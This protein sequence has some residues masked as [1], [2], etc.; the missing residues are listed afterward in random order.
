MVY[1]VKRNIFYNTCVK[2]F[3]G[4]ENRWLLNQNPTYA[5]ALFLSCIILFRTPFCSCTR[6]RPT[7]SCPPTH[8]ARSRP[9]GAVQSASTHLPVRQWV[10]QIPQITTDGIGGDWGFQG[11]TTRMLSCQGHFPEKKQHWHHGINDLK[12]QSSSTW[13]HANNPVPDIKIGESIEFGGKEQGGAREEARH[14]ETYIFKVQHNKAMNYYRLQP[15]CLFERLKFEIRHYRDDVGV[16]KTFYEKEKDKK[17]PAVLT[18][19]LQVTVRAVLYCTQLNE[20]RMS[21]T[22]IGSRRSS[23]RG[24]DRYNCQQISKLHY[25]QQAPEHMI[26]WFKI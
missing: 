26:V 8:L 21:Q 1:R 20:I 14:T 16:K 9:R 23:P 4:V 24:A 25:A 13:R 17:L 19:Y 2:Q 18:S 6:G 5:I 22:N 3:F 10:P 15:W 11:K 12:Q 7:F